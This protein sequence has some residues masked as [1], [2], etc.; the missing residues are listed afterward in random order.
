MDLLPKVF[1]T[2]GTIAD[3]DPNK[4]YV[5]ILKETGMSEEDA[6]SI[7]EIVVRRII[8]SGIKFLSGPHIREI[9][10]SILSEEHFENER[11]LYTRIGMPLMDYEEILEKSPIEDLYK[12]V[13][14]EKIHHWAGN[15]IAEEY[16]HLRI[17]NNEE[18]KAHLA[19]DIHINGLN[20]FVLRPFIQI[21]DPRLILKNGLPPMK[22]L[23][24]YY[25]YSPAKNLKSALYQLAKWLEMIQAEFYGYQGFNFINTFL[26][27]YL[28]ELNENE[29]SKD[30]KSFIYEN[31]LLSLSIG[32]EVPPISIISTI[33]VPKE[34]I[35]TPAVTLSGKTKNI[36]GNFQNQCTQFFKTIFLIFKS[37]YEKNP[38]LSLPKHYILLNPEFFDLIEGLI[39]KFWDD[40]ELLSSAYFMNLNPNSY[41]FKALADLNKETYQNFG[42][43]QN[44]SLNLPRY[45]FSTKDEDKF[46]ELLGLKLDLCS[47]IL[48]KKYDIIK[49]RID[50]KHL[51]LCG[52]IVEGEQLFKLHNQGLS[53]SLVGLNEAIK[54]ITDYDLHESIDIINFGRK[55]LNEINQLCLEYSNN[56]NKIFLLSENLSEKAIN[57]FTNSDL[58]QFPD[59][60]RYVANNRNYTNSVNL[61]EGLSI[62]VLERVKIQ[63]NF[64]EFIHEGATINISLTELKRNGL[65]IKDFLT[66]ISKESRISNLKFYS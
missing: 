39:P 43:L 10:C 26:A 59:K 57:R 60:V 14:P 61:R 9:V 47:N 21:W 6:K 3:F 66:K 1:R 53:V 13:N 55:I 45:A 48:L 42:I 11:K 19:G 32:R 24:G 20:Y 8:S 44:I 40:I 23:K 46:L 37:I 49:K 34:L 30:I 38:L 64:H 4:I 54:Y 36:Y 5:S 56:N 15:K 33:T 16:A 12:L 52:T 51:P 22:T 41:K 7:T 62:D 50:S 29:I 28:S 63:E 18:S 25:K 31:N 35:N 65:T 2:E 17:L 27:P 58:K